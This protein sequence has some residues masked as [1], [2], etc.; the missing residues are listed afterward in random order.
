MDEWYILY[1]DRH[2][3]GTLLNGD[4]AMLYI[5]IYILLRDVHSLTKWKLLMRISVIMNNE[6]HAME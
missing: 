2:K 6:L 3:C 5:Y 4:I 1:T